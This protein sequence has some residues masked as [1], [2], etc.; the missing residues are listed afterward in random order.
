MQRAVFVLRG[1]A[2]AQKHTNISNVRVYHLREAFIAHLRM[3]VI[4]TAESVLML[5]YPPNMQPEL[6]GGDREGSG[7][8][9]KVGEIAFVIK[10]LW[11]SNVT[12]SSAL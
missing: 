8:H 4:I 12:R 7:P 11:A 6:D 3:T 9:P 5:R 2:R 1:H 10:R